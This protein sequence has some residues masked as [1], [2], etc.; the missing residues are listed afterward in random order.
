[1]GS[2]CFSIC[3]CMRACCRLWSNKLLKRMCLFRHWLTTTSVNEVLTPNYP[4]Y[5]LFVLR[6]KHRYLCWAK[7]LFRKIDADS[8]IAA[9]CWAFLASAAVRK[10][11]GLRGYNKKKTP[12]GYTHINIL[13]LTL[14]LSSSHFLRMT[15]DADSSG[16]ALWLLTSL[17]TCG[18]VCTYHS[19]LDANPLDRPLMIGSYTRGKYMTPA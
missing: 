1:M 19:G 11:Y 6:A 18:K 17:T 13:S 3:F 14:T 5:L 15:G 7:Q 2:P 12:Q 8:T 4:A 9:C 10:N 16:A